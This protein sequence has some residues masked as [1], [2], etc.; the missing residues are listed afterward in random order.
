M[1]LSPE[2]QMF[3]VT[4]NES[5]WEHQVDLDPQFEVLEMDFSSSF[6]DL[7]VNEKLETRYYQ[8]YILAF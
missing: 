1:Y 7:S 5:T 2:P 4:T 3:V 8:K 6:S